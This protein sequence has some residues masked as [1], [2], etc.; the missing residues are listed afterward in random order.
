[1]F[2]PVHKLI[3]RNDHSFD[4]VDPIFMS[5]LYY[6]QRKWIIVFVT[7]PNV[8]TF[9]INQ[10]H[11]IPFELLSLSYLLH[12]HQIFCLA[13][14]CHGK[15]V[16]FFLITLLFLLSKP[17]T[18]FIKSHCHQLNSR[19]ISGC[20]TIKSHRCWAAVLKFRV[21]FVRIQRNSR[22]ACRD[23]RRIRLRV[24]ESECVKLTC[25]RTPW[26]HD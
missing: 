7:F 24:N 15:C 11:F 22:N 26:N 19:R 16:F 6:T 21:T 14:K 20:I 8:S 2:W 25:V 12:F 10:I 4:P 23:M 1:M 18:S 3:I 9:H 5:F 17:C 13:F